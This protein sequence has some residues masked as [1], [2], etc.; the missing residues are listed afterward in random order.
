MVV[1]GVVVVVV[2]AMV[3]A[4]VVVA[5]VSI[6]AVV[7]GCLFSPVTQYFPPPALNGDF[8]I[9]F[10]DIQGSPLWFLESSHYL[11]P[12]PGPSFVKNMHAWQEASNR[13]GKVSPLL[14]LSAQ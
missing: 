14:A 3:A 8:R 5:T 11:S 1:G 6:G 10:P 7:Q 4:V 13:S 12:T 9:F 2:V